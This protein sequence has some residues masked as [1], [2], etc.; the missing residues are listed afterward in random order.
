MPHFLNMK[1][2]TGT[3][4]RERSAR[5]PHQGKIIRHRAAVLLAATLSAV[6]GEHAALSAT[7]T[8]PELSDL[9]FSNAFSTGWDEPW[10]KRSRGD[11]TPDMPL[12]RVQTNFLGQQ[13]FR[14][15]YAHQENLSSASIRATDS[16]TGTLEYALNRRLMLAVIGNYGWL[17]S[18]R[19]SDF[20]GATGGAFVRL[21]WVDTAASS[22]ATTL[23]VMAPNHDLGEKDTTLSLA[24]SG[25]RDL[26]RM[27]LKRTGLY[28]HV[29]EETLVGPVKTGGRR[30]DFT[31]AVSLAKTWSS[32]DSLFGNATTFVEAYGK[33]DLDGNDS[34]HIV[35]A[36]L[37]F[38][39]R[40]HGLSSGSS[41]SPTSATSDPAMRATSIRGFVIRGEP[42]TPE[43]VSFHHQTTTTTE[44]WTSTTSTN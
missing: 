36:G 31:Y 40:T 33:T 35:M 15:D 42:N 29:Q 23:K 8:K 20:E 18:R 5:I 3:N 21:Q 30:N 38:P 28:W 22:I 11:G 4:R 41:D 9:T 7:A 32:P 43:N 10:T 17:D 14:T 19:L 2:T 34:G 13:V 24:I 37:I 1:T 44:L 25:W 6:A 27:G 39:S 16:L 26:A 12:L